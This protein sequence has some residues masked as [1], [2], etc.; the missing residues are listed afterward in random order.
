MEKTRYLHFDF[1][2]K[3]KAGGVMIE[4]ISNAAVAD[5][6]KEMIHPKEW[7]IDNYKKNP[8]VL[9]DHGKDVAF[10]TIPV[11]KA[12]EVGPT[13]TGLFTKI[14]M[15][16]SK[17]EKIS[18]IR[19]LV[20]EGI[21]KT[22]SVGFNPS[23]MVDEGG[24]KMLKGCELM[25]QSI[26]PIPMNQDSMFSVASKRFTRDNPM[27]KHWFDRHVKKVQLIQKGSWVAAALHQTIYDQ[28]ETSQIADRD[29]FIKS[30]ADSA[31]SKVSEIHDVLAGDL[32]P[33]PP[34]IVDAFAK[35][36]RLD[37]D[38]LVNLDKGDVA[39]MDRVLYRSEQ[40]ANQEGKGMASKKTK[41]VGAPGAVPPAGE[42]PPAD[43]NAP[44]EQN[45]PGGEEPK[46][47]V[48]A[49]AIPKT[50]ADTADA[51]SSLAEQHGFKVDAIEENET[52]WVIAQRATD[53]LD[54]E[55]ATM[56]DLGDGA[57]A[58]AAP[59]KTAPKAAAETDAEKAAKEAAEKAKTTPPAAP[60]AANPPAAGDGAPPP[61]DGAP[62]PAAMD[63]AVKEYEAEVAATE[64]DKP[65]NPP[66]WVQDE[67]LWAKAKQASQDG[68]KKISYPFVVW[69]YL[70]QGGGKKSGAVA[71]AKGVDGQ[72][73]DDNP[74]LTLARQTNVF[75][76]TL[77]GET[78][79][80]S[81]KLDG[82]A[83]LSVKLATQDGG[84]EPP[85]PAE[86]AKGMDDLARYKKDF[87]DYSQKLEMGLKRL[88]G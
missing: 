9:F 62:D 70:K 75:L 49:V 54:M 47:V 4:G 20:E 23:S 12:T 25:E 3:K 80:M 64:G 5:R 53:D 82:L 78:Q 33:V 50:M 28:M 11:G 60:A 66:A 37:K 77:I 34:R 40:A 55:E 38:F 2:M 71:Q 86:P 19:D 45:E 26:V 1:E 16:N 17:T 79:Q 56:V 65:G 44:E 41:D 48:Y 63:A 59:V 32:T 88:N 7:R 35:V 14:M 72:Q 46:M 29:A 76:A 42:N 51:A 61:A 57:I 84:T 24:I 18:A 85:P 13:D 68:L 21:L 10:G 39:L 83:D 43:P 36:L 15:S 87:A 8:I 22:F 81:K 6:A 73:L 67:A 74:Y 58:L 52:Q 31:G 27:A 30:V 69:W